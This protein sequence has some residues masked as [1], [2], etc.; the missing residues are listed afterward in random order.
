[1]SLRSSAEARG[2]K[3]GRASLGEVC[4]EERGSASED[5]AQVLIGGL[6]IGEIHWKAG[7]EQ[8]KCIFLIG[9][10]CW[11]WREVQKSLSFVPSLDR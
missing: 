10:G 7:G 2:G 3:L 6:Q 1:M 4:R 11:N 5:F 9:G 8:S